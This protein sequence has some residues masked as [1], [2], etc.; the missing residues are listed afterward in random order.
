MLCGVV[1][2]STLYQHSEVNNDS[3]VCLQSAEI[4]TIQKFVSCC[5][6]D[7]TSYSENTF[8][9]HYMIISIHPSFPFGLVNTQGTRFIQQP[10]FIVNV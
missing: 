2:T 10:L 6:K 8:Y 4:G 9:Q 1:Y 3:V 7:C 5:K